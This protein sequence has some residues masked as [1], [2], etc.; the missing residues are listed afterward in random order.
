MKEQYPGFDLQRELQNPAFV[1]LTAPGVGVSVEEAYC[2]IHSRQLREAAAAASVQQI[3][4]A[5]RAGA[6]RPEENGTVTA[7]AVTAFDYKNASAQQREALRRAI[8]A[9]G[10]RGEKIYPGQEKMI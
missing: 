8:R 4:N 7:P 10:A 3:S 1:R 2:A 5:I 6:M 9:A